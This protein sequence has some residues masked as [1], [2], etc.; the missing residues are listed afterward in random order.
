MT[1]PWS[2][3]RGMKMMMMAGKRR[4]GNHGPGGHRS[5]FPMGPGPFFP[6]KPK[7][8]RGDVRIAI[9]H[10]LSEQP[11]HGYQI[12]QE[13]SQRTDGVWNP[14]PGSVYPT[15]QQLEDEGLVRSDQR[16]GKN[17]FS[18]TDDGADAL[19]SEDQ[20]PPWERMAGGMSDNLLDLREA[21]FQV[22][23]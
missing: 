13:I 21:G 22:G 14:S 15:L 23:A 20:T 12:I 9:L 17:V 16:D 7:V 5:Q 11:M 2:G 1:P 18:L 6:G 3:P 10:L 4:R 8:G 19:G